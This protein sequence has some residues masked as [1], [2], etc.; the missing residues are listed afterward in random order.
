MSNHDGSYML[1]DVLT[2]LDK[3]GVWEQMPRA[4]T[5]QLVV[6]IVRLACHR[7]D[8]NAGEILDG[9]EKLGVCYYCWSPAETLRRGICRACRAKRGIDKDDGDETSAEVEQLSGVTMQQTVEDTVILRFPNT[10]AVLVR[11]L[12][13][14]TNLNQLV[15]LQRDVLQAPNQA[16]V[17]ALLAAIAPAV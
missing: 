4:R 5:Q 14:L 9:H 11:K 13:S 10:P 8:C 17:E 7:H 1:R 15:A 16:A 3:A 2:L 6:E 12:R